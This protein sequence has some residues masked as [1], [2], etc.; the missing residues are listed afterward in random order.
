MSGEQH[1]VSLPNDYDNAKPSRLLLS[2][3]GWGGSSTSCGSACSTHFTDHGIITVSLSGYGGSWN[4]VGT[5]ASPGQDGA[6][7]TPNATDYCYDDCGSCA[8]NCWWTTCKDSV[9]QTLQV[10]NKVESELCINPAQIWAMGCSNGAMFMFELAADPRIASRLAGVFPVVGQPH[11]GFNV[12]PAVGGINLMGFYG[13]QDTT[14][15]PLSNT[16][17]P[18]KSFDT[19]SP[20]WYF[21]TARNVTSLWAQ[22]G[23]CDG[24]EFTSN[25]SIAQYADSDG[26]SCVRATDCN[27]ANLEII[28]CL[29]DGGHTCYKDYQ[30]GPILAFI[31]DNNTTKST[32]QLDMPE[33]IIGVTI[34]TLCFIMFVAVIIGV[35]WRHRRQKYSMLARYN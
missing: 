3:H 1:L 30:V 7:C 14:I 27:D 16:D 5:T 2:F 13:L 29:F 19:A 31:M 12:P 34:G 28:E 33:V 15:P 32:N 23:G 26:L 35:M 22:Y 21:N 10:L 24:W 6:T 20:G 8:D 17:D 25:W 11:N 4:G 18:T 9:D